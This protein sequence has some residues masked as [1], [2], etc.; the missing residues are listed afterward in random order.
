MSL[1]L[2]RSSRK[3]EV[4]M[5]AQIAI[6]ALAVGLGV[7]YLGY[8]KQSEGALSYQVPTVGEI[9][10]SMQNGTFNDIS[11]PIPPTI[12]GRPRAINRLPRAHH[13]GVFVD[14]PPPIARG[15]RSSAAY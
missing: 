5:N 10:Q 4:R 7:Y 3:K 2:S 8:A 13:G 1:R 6:A 12:G 14:R 11:T 15:S 9:Q